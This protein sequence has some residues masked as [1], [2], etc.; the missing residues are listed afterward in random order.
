MTTRRTVLKGMTAAGGL[1]A[2]PQLLHAQA[3]TELNVI[4]VG[5]PESHITP[6]AEMFMKNNPTI[7]LKLERIP[8]NELFP[9]LEVRLQARTPLPDIFFADGPLTASYSIRKHLAELDGI[10]GNDLGHYT[11]AALA[12]GT[13]K[14]KL[15]TLPYISSGMVLFL[16]RKHFADAGVALPEP[17]VAKR[18]TWEQTLEA[19]KKLT[20][21]AKNQWGLVFEM[22]DRPYQALTLPQSKGAQVLSE[23]GLTATG[24]VD[25]QP[26]IDAMQF[27]ADLFNKHKVTPTGVFDTNLALEMFATG[28]ASMYL[29]T[30]PSL[31]SISARKD[32]DWTVAPQPYFEGGKAVTPTGS[33]HIGMNPRTKQRAAAETFIKAFAQPEYVEAQARLRPNPPVLK[34]V[35]DS[36]GAELDT[37]GWRIV[38]SEMEN[39]AVPRPATPGW[40]E[41]EDI[42]RG[43]FREIQGGANVEQRLKKAARDIDREF[44]KYRG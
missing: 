24:Y 41:Y 5:W 25:S 9:A 10:L 44:A 37:P 27:Y 26:F 36:M 1:L 23:D 15:M 22:A 29:A 28:R 38:R 33:W 19:A 18:W 20:D 13:Y 12:Q 11:K 3:K 31:A 35:W 16:N 14:G 39:T 21:P 2:A 42:L 17:D 30:T 8:F 7:G 43:A 34:S 4:W 6:M 40:L 32:L